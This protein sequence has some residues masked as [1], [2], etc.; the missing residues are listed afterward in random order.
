VRE[1]R[2]GWATYLS[3]VQD[4]YEFGVLD[5]V[6]VVGGLRRPGWRLELLLR[7]G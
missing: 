4:L 7:V 2:C 5:R 6:G 3:D 1:P